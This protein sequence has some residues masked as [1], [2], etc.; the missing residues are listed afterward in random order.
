MPLK[1]DFCLTIFEKFAR[2]IAEN[3][4]KLMTGSNMKRKFMKLCSLLLALPV[5]L[6]AS[7]AF[8]PVGGE[9]NTGDET[10]DGSAEFYMIATVENLSDPFQVNVIEAEYASGPF[11]LV[12]SDATVYEDKDG[13]PLSKSS[14]KVGDTVKIYYSGQVMMSYPPQIVARRIVKQ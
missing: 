11:W 14:L 10:E 3:K 6:L 1:E 8:P 2:I 4:N 13:N 5:L 7:C 9:E 12:T